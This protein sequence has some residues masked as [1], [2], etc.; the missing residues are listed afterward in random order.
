MWRRHRHLPTHHT[1]VGRRCRPGCS[2]VLPFGGT[3]STPSMTEKNPGASGLAVVGCFCLLEGRLPRRPRGKPGCSAVLPFGGTA[4][5]PSMTE[6]NPGDQQPGCSLFGCSV[7]G[8]AEPGAVGCFCSSVQCRKNIR[9]IRPV[10]SAFSC[11]S[12]FPVFLPGSVAEGFPHC[13]KMGRFCST[14]WKNFSRIF[15]TM[16]QL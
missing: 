1:A 15:H 14:Q 10:F 3:A 4:S 13:G 6:K 9:R 11:F 8:R 7:A 12:G 16:E 2:A 5:T